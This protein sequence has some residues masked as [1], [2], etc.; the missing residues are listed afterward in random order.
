MVTNVVCTDTQ[1]SLAVMVIKHALAVHNLKHVLNGIWV[2]Q[3]PF[4]TH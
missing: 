1:S 4:K 2:L 3:R